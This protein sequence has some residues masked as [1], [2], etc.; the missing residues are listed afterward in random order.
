M[1]Q[2]LRAAS[3]MA[4]ATSFIFILRFS[5]SQAPCTPLGQW[6][7]RAIAF[8]STARAADSGAA[9]ARQNVAEIGPS[10]EVWRLGAAKS[11][12]CAP[13]ES[14]EPGRGRLSAAA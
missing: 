5:S 2:P 13:F 9:C 12:H 11:L 8:R 10:A 7:R 4:A 6:Y 3:D 1:A 14:A